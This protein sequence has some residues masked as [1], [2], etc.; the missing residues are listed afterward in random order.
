VRE[1]AE[2]RVWMGDEALARGLVDACGGL[3]DAIVLAREKA[4][5]A[6]D[7]EVQLVEYPPR[8]LFP[9]P[10]LGPELPRP[11][12]LLQSAIAWLD[13]DADDL[14]ALSTLS[15]A[16]VG[17]DET[18]PGASPLLGITRPVSEEEELDYDLLYLQTLARSA[19]A[20]VLVM[21]PDL[22]PA[23]DVAGR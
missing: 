6:P 21:P 16:G 17:G 1:L 5:L 23:A 20:P 8:P 11:F 9:W 12:G 7:A 18:S 10:H 2:G 14:T 22:L 13:G 3:L 15:T 4:G 19:G